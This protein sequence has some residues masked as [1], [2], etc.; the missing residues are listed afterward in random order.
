M[1]ALTLDN[2]G[3]IDIGAILLDS[4]GVGTGEGCNK[5]EDLHQL[6]HKAEEIGGKI[7]FVVTQ[8]PVVRTIEGY[9][10]HKT[11]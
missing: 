7:L 10:P 8:L 3:G 1:Q 5:E 6:V 4:G 2:K 11:S 9:I